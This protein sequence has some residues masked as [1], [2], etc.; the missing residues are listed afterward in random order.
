MPFDTGTISILDSERLMANAPW[1]ERYLIGV[2]YEAFASPNV[3][4]SYDALDRNTASYEMPNVIDR[5]NAE[6]N[7]LGFNQT[8]QRCNSMI[9]LVNNLRVIL[10]N[11]QRANYLDWLVGNENVWYWEEAKQQE[12]WKLDDAAL[13][14]FCNELVARNKQRLQHGLG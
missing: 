11:S 1:I 5:L 8:V 6:L 7:K 9:D 10:K 4:P 13:L 2:A 14:A 3:S 12:A